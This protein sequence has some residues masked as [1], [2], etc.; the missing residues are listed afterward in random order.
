M[1]DR[2]SNAA[3]RVESVDDHAPISERRPAGKG[4]ADKVKEILALEKS[5]Q[6]GPLRAAL[7]LVDVLDNWEL[8]RVEA[9]GLDGVTWASKAF[10][11][12]HAATY[13]RN[14]ADAVEALVA[15]K[16]T[17]DF[18]LSRFDHDVAVFLTGK[19]IP[20][21]KQR[22]VVRAVV[23]EQKRRQVLLN[24]AIATAL[25][26]KLLGR[27]STKRA[28]DD[29]LAVALA[30]IEAMYAAAKEGKDLP[31]M[32]AGLQGLAKRPERMTM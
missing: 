25:V 29:R 32:P 10:G 31:A 12:K 28:T 22:E 3:P 1:S 13:Y 23:E 4:L 6:V 30:H 27:K 9:D 19:T 7:A 5:S 24:H 17:K 8:Y 2:E 26:G 11:R 18:V 21:D 14:R 20:M 15:L 16:Y